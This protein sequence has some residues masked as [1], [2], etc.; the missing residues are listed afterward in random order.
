MMAEVFFTVCLVA[1]VTSV[2]LIG[3]TLL[4]VALNIIKV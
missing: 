1:G 2:G 3:L 4:G